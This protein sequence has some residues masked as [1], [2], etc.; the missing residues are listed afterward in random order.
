MSQRVTPNSGLV[1]PKRL[2]AHQRSCYIR[3]LFCYFL[4]GTLSES[5]AILTNIHHGRRI[6]QKAPYS[7][8]LINTTHRLPPPKSLFS[9]SSTVWLEIGPCERRADDL[10]LEAIAS[11]VIPG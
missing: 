8:S 11:E 3:C 1:I 9:V 5:T 4:L 6:L 10:P 2:I 7:A